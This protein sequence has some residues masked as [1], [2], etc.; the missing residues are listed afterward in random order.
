MK[1]I[2][3]FIKVSLLILGT[4]LLLSSCNS[5]FAQQTDLSFPEI[6]ITAT[7]D[8]ISQT[9]S[10]QSE[11]FQTGEMVMVAI[12][13]NGG[14]KVIDQKIGFG[15]PL[16]ITGLASGNYVVTISKDQRFGNLKFSLN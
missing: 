16:P 12:F 7:Y 1:K 4:G 6:S 5:A 3:L 8:G 14:K 2:Q 15:N 9:M 13:D 11:G 10:F